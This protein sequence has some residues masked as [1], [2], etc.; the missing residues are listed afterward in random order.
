MSGP[1]VSPAVTAGLEY[2]PPTERAMAAVHAAVAKRDGPGRIALSA[3]PVR[4]NRDGEVEKLPGGAEV[5]HRF[6]EGPGDEETVLWHLVEGGP[7]GAPTVVFLHG[8]PDSWYLWHHQ[9]NDLSADHH[10]IS[11]DLKGYGQSEKR[12]GDYRQEGVSEQFVGLLD[13]LGIDKAHFVTHDRGTPY[14][15]HLAARHPE[16]IDKF[17]RGEQHCYYWHPDVSPQAQWFMD[18]NFNLFRHPEKLVGDLYTVLSTRPVSTEDLQRTVRESS[19]PDIDKAVPRY[20]Q[21]NTFRKEWIR[22]H[23]D[24]IPRWKCPILI[25]QGRE[26]PFQPYEYFE[27]LAE[28]IPNSTVEFVAA[29]HY[30]PHEAPEE[31]T[32]KIAAFVRGP[33]CV[34]S[35]PR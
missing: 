6:V 13:Q 7:E 1:Y 4:P 32:E 9:M 15:E 35:Y 2:T 22:R 5:T 16:R 21:A 11:V 26:D 29:G 24:L 18:P 34:R 28:V 3:E 31:T 30:F 27:H 20:F 12:P 14:I 8:I 10:V 17:V 25:L 19:H 33:A 23:L